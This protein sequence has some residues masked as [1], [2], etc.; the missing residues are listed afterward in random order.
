M[1]APGLL[2]FPKGYF[3]DLCE[4]KRSILSWIDEASELEI[5]GIEMYPHFY[6]KISQR[7]I[8]EIHDYARSK[9]LLVPMMC[10][11]PDFTKPRKEEREK[12]IDQMRFWIEVMGKTDVPGRIK[13]CR[14]LSGQRRPGISRSDGESWVIDAIEKLIPCAEENEV[15]LVMENH[16]KDGR[17]EYPEFAQFPDVYEDIVDSI[18]SKWFGIN[19]DPSNALVSGQ[20]PIELLKRFRNRVLTMHASDRHLKPG[21]TVR[22]LEKFSGKGYPEALEHGVIGTGL[23]NYDEIFRIIRDSEFSGWISIEDGVNG[24]E[25]LVASVSFLRGMLSKYFGENATPRKRH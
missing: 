12:E 15:H 6:P 5:D 2:A 16:Y 14:V 11:S 1:N 23:I 17:W 24:H 18:H 19:F 7:E 3:D 8:A 22:D 20:D 10:T 4:G 21:Y 13:T 25:D 9:K